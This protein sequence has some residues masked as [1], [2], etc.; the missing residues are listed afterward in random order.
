MQHGALEMFAAAARLER[1]PFDACPLCDGTE[2]R[3]LKSVSCTGHALY[4]SRLPPSIEW[5]QCAGCYHVFTTGHFGKEALKVLFSRTQESQQPGYD[6][7]RQREIA[8]AMVDRV[9]SARGGVLGDWLDV[10]FGAGA[11][12]ATAAEYGFKATGLDLRYPSVELMRRMGY[13]ARCCPIEA[14]E[15]EA[16]DVISLCDVVEHVPF[17][18]EL[19]SATRSRLRLDGVVLISMPNS[20]SFVWRALDSVGK[21]PYWSE[22]EHFHNFSRTSLYRL[23]A[24]HYLEPVSF[25]I[26]RR[27]RCSMEV[28]AR[29]A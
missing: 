18:G 16:F 3:P 14:L 8:G 2:I 24:K 9:V 12:F 10:G 11:V 17:P 20:E 27:Y 6:M 13:D 21:N 7:E 15:G 23:L 22:I 5:V 29:A 19:L 1:L 26:S 4:D 28:I 25:G